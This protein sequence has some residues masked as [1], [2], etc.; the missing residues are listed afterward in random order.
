MKHIVVTRSVLHHVYFRDAEVNKPAVSQSLKPMA[1]PKA[2][3]TQN[4]G[5]HSKTVIPSASSKP[6]ETRKNISQGKATKHVSASTPADTKKRVIST[7]KVKPG[8]A[9]PPTK[10]LQNTATPSTKPRPVAAFKP[11]AISLSAKDKEKNKYVLDLAGGTS[12]IPFRTK[13]KH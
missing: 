1:I 11:A 7:S 3:A 6:T 13:K 4:G 2:S 12:K 5:S 9:S 10:P 8:T